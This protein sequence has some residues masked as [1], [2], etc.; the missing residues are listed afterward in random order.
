MIRA[1]NL[2][3]VN[4]SCTLVAALTLTQFTNVREAAGDRTD[5]IRLENLETHLFRGIYVGKFAKQQC[6]Q[7]LLTE[8]QAGNELGCTARHGAVRV[9]RFQQIGSEHQ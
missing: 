9:E 7:R 5:R 4:K 2:E 6:K 1:S 8:T 3:A